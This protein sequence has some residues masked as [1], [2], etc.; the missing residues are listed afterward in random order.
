MSRDQEFGPHWLS[1]RASILLLGCV[2]TPG[3]RYLEKRGKIRV[4][5]YENAVQSLGKGNV[6]VA[7]NHPDA[8]TPF[9]MTGV[10][11]QLYYRNPRFCLWNVPR[12]GLMPRG[13]KGLF[14]S[15]E[16]HR[17]D[18]VARDR[19]VKR[20][21]EV[22]IAGGNAL[23]F[24]EETR[25]EAR[26]GEEPEYL[27]HNGRKIRRIRSGVPLLTRNTYSHILPVWIDFPGIVGRPGIRGSIK[28]LMSEPDRAITI[29][30]G[31]PYQI[32]RRFKL[33]EENDRLGRLILELSGQVP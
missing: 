16:L 8:I 6:I 5:G 12:D 27:W 19:S 24:V 23:I 26:D 31:D 29:V 15:I 3:Y 17:T 10:F 33:A 30:F 4:I 1:G 20:L 7:A 14:R 28:Q 13:T 11:N 18:K 2:L 9:L 25:T 21:Q 22:L 32:G